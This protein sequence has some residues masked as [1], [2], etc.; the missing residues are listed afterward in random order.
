MRIVLFTFL[1]AF[2]TSCK[3]DTVQTYLLESE[4][5]PELVSYDFSSDM[6]AFAKNFIEEAEIPVIKSIDKVKLVGLNIEDNSLEAYEQEKQRLQT[7]L[8]NSEY[9]KLLNIKKDGRQIKIYYNGE[10]EAIDEVL[11]FGYSDD[12]GVGLARVLGNNI[13]P[14]EIMEVV[15]N[16]KLN[17]LINGNAFE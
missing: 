13:N 16:K 5:R 1:I 2:F 11:V 9:K 14:T 7:I 3:K 8:E 17:S 15:D 12:Q 10:Q 6:L 4:N